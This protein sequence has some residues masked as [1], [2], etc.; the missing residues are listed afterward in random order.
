MPKTNETVVLLCSNIGHSIPRV[1][2][3]AFMKYEQVPKENRI[4]Q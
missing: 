3:L 1:A 2:F 4:G